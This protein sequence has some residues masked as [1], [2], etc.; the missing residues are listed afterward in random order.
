MSPP[1][2]ERPYLVTRTRGVHVAD[3]R[4]PQPAPVRWAV[5]AD[6]ITV[7]IDTP[8]EAG[9]CQPI[10]ARLEW[11][12]RTGRAT[13]VV[14]DI[15]GCSDPDLGAVDALAR[16]HVLVRRQGR[17][18]RVVGASPQLR[19][20]LAAVGLDRLLGDGRPSGR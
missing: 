10:G 11:H 9:E 15:G 12:L 14:C 6:V 8:P 13:A 16:L 3:G 17:D 4:T 7:F 18:V 5:G 1:V 19:Q 2:R 20:L